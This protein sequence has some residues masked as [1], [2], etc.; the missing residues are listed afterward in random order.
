MTCRL[1]HSNV[2]AAVFQNGLVRRM[3]VPLAHTFVLVL[4][5]EILDQYC[6]KGLLEISVHRKRTWRGVS[7]TWKVVL[8]DAFHRCNREG[9]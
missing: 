9:W 4:D 2:F 8:R 7:P 1:R 5:W 6:P 3:F